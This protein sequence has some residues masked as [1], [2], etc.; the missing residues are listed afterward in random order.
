MTQGQTVGLLPAIVTVDIPHELV[1]TPPQTGVPGLAVAAHKPTLD[2]DGLQI[3][4]PHVVGI[5][6]QLM[7]PPRAPRLRSHQRRRGSPS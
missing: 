3:Q 5:T 4:I 1:P 2:I 7:F 6:L